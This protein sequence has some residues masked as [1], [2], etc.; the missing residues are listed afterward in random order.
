[1]TGGNVAALSPSVAILRPMAAIAF[2][3]A[4]ALFCALLGAWAL[5]TRLVDLPERHF[6]LGALA[7]QLLPALGVFVALYGVGHQEPTSDVPGFYMPA[8]R[9]IL[10]GQ[11]P[12]R[13]F[14]LSYAPLFAYVGAAL[15][16]VWNSGK[17]FALFAILLNGVALV[18]WHRAALACFDRSTV[19]HCTI[20]YATSG[21]VLSQA[22]L[23]TN[24]AWVSAGLAASAM[25]MARD[26]SASSGVVQA[27]AAAITKILAHLFWPVLWICA[28][29]R[30]H[31][32][33]AAV[34]PV[35][36]V[37]GAF[38]VAGAGTGLLHPLR[39][40]GELISP[41]NL[42]YVL[43]L[44]LAAAGSYERLIFDCVA[45]AALGV[46]TLWL[47]L[48]ARTL[49][50]RGRQNLVLAGLA[51][52]GLVFMLFSKKS[53]TGYV[54]FVLYPV[55][56]MLVCGVVERRARVAFLLAFNVLLV[57]E[58]SVW[59]YLKGNGLSLRTWLRT[60]NSAAILGFVALD[61]ALLACYVYL[62]WL[63]VRGVRTMAA[64]AIR[65]KNSSQSATACALV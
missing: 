40:E 43:D 2:K 39:Y 48:N 22:L 27:I 31:W 30:L 9:A 62:A 29:R 11:L 32:L 65:S 57:A 51:L 34:L 28:H 3:V 5:R 36:A 10:A 13:D 45:L 21:H 12:Y 41:G 4:L 6:L 7:L 24:Q 42:P 14:A 64:G 18:W 58:P 33:V 54:I 23:G 17:I 38:V 26:Q 60:G 20:L 63:S 55:I 59:F 25:L 35:T 53:F 19:R 1:M 37:Y 50:P 47:Y 56:L 46:T 15:V 61:C 44:V 49:T 8:A 16:S 52:T